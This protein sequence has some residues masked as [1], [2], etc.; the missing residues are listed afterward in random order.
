MKRW[1]VDLYTRVD[2]YTGESRTEKNEID[3]KSGK[4]A[5]CVYG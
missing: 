4:I 2:L 5:S 3:V 1:F